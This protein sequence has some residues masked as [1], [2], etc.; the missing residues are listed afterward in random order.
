MATRNC[1]EFKGYMPQK[2]VFADKKDKNT[3]IRMIC[4]LMFTTVS[5]RH[6]QPSRLVSP[7]LVCWVLFA[8]TTPSDAS[9]Q[10]AS[11]GQTSKQPGLSFVEHRDHQSPLAL[12]LV[13]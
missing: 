1:Q 9:I 4:M 12:V 8:G 6:L 13:G 7:R 10:I 11:L 5:S 2:I 3:V